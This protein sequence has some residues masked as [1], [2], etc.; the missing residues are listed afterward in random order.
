MSEAKPRRRWRRL[1]IILAMLVLLPILSVAVVTLTLDTEALK[2]RITAAVEAATGRR[3][4]L[5]GP[6][7]F[8]PA[9]VPTI[10]IEDVALANTAGGSA[11]HMLTARRIEL[12]LALLPLLSRA[13]DIRSLTIVEPRLL[14]ETDAEGRPNWVFAAAPPAT[15]PTGAPANP[16]PAPP[17]EPG[18]G[19]TLGVHSLTLTD[20]TLTWRDGVSGTTRVLAI[21]RL[22]TRAT[23]Q[24]LT[25]EA[26]LAVE[27]KALRLRGETGTIAAFQAPSA[28]W[29]L[30]LALE[31][32]GVTLTVQGEAA[33]P[34]RMR[35]WRGHAE[36]TLDSL[37]RLAAFMPQLATLPP[38]NGITFRIAAHEAGGTAIIDSLRVGAG[39]TDLT[40]LRPGLALRS[41]TLAVEAADAPVTIA[42]EGAL[43]RLPLALTGTLGRLS[44][45]LAGAAAPLPVD[46]T[47]TAADA[48][49]RLQGMAGT[50]PAGA[51]LDLAFAARVPDAAALAMLA[52]MR[53]PALR[54]IAATGRLAQ[55]EHGRVT[56]RDLRATSSAGNVAGAL[57]LAMGA[58]PALTGTLTS[59]RIDL[60]ALDLAPA[61]VPVAPPAPAA[62]VAPS[63]APG[64]RR[65]IPEMGIDLV[66]LRGADADL[67]FTIATLQAT[68]ELPLT[69]VS[70]HL[71]L[72]EGQL[73]LDRI[74]ATTPGGAMSGS[75]AADARATPAALRL[76]LRGDGINLA[77]LRPSLGDRFGHGTG[78]VDIAL[79]GTGADTRALAASLDGHLGLALV[80][81]RISQ[82]LLAG[83]PPDLLRLLVPQGIPPEGLPLR[84]FALR[85]PVSGGT[86][87]AHTFL[88]ETSIGRIGAT[89][90]IHLADERIELRLLPNLRTG[91]INLRAPIPLAGT[92]AAPRLGR[93]DAAAAAAAGLNALL[94]TQRTPDRTLEG[95]SEAL[96][97]GAPTLPE[98]DV[99]LAAARAGRPG[100][101]PATP[102]PVTPPTSAPGEAPRAPNAADILRGLLGGTRR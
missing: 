95:A 56:L 52:D 14:L 64:P 61:T 97:G 51:G 80:D 24:A 12:R 81:G 39:A 86:L 32:E 69:A 78:D 36:G 18:A 89:G 27:G 55:P 62:A 42:A 11:P 75:I 17:R 91:M 20:G 15:P 46:V 45:L 7:S 2:P 70:A 65:V 41:L 16:I 96:G 3:L 102:A 90:A 100:A 66:A 26:R 4:E 73:L 6:V 76:A 67:R 1:L 25:H 35:G 98:C 92:L 74:A 71:V 84:C 83:I 37:A 40:T 8:T 43:G 87:R 30:R 50:L 9:L 72:R 13:I 77:A 101:A 58:R 94:G 10:A 29:P 88:A 28:P 5:R 79:S 34:A 99:A 23:A 82:S 68:P 31:T 53:A 19:L 49:L 33:E 57:T 21:E 85:A 22:T 59:D 48:S 54:D 63:P 93:V 38:A 44:A 47:L 60:T